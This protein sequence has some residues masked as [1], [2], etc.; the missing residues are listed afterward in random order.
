MNKDF[1]R[2]Y[3]QLHYWGLASSQYDFS[4]RWLGQCSSY[5]SSMMARNAQP[6]IEAILSLLARLRSHDEKLK[7]T[8]AARTNPQMAQL[9]CM[10]QREADALAEH[11]YDASLQRVAQRHSNQLEANP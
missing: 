8:D 6:G 2:I 4:Q 7:S 1:Q 5:Y 10:L 9:Q 3:S 11:L